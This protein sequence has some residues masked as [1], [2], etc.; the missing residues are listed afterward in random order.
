MGSTCFKATYFF[1][2]IGTRKK[3]PNQYLKTISLLYSMSSN[4]KWYIGRKWKSKPNRNKS[5]I[6]FYMSKV[7]RV[8]KCIHHSPS[9]FNIKAKVHNSGVENSLQWVLSDVES[10]QDSVNFAKPAGLI[11]PNI[12]DFIYSRDSV[13]DLCRELVEVIDRY[14]LLFQ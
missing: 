10:W 6:L 2:K 4:L 14:V 11:H 1:Q 5:S 3:A 7:F 12:S 8:S 9:V 13:S